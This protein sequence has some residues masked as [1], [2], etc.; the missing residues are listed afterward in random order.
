MAEFPDATY[1]TTGPGKGD[2]SNSGVNANK[3]RENKPNARVFAIIQEE[4]NEANDVVT[5]TIFIQQ[6]PAYVLFDCSATH[7]FMSKRFSKKLGY[8]LEKLNEPFRIATPT[9]RAIETH[10]IYRDCKISM[11]N[12]TFSADLIQLVM[13]DFDIILG[14]EWLARNSAIV[15][16]KGNRVNLRTPDQE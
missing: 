15:D 1:R 5:C 13:V 12:Q 10:E 4:A 14:M 3:P 8:K 7:S 11:G 16:C 2:G 9:S 6:V